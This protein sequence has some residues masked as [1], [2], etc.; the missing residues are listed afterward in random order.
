[1]S[2]IMNGLICNFILTKE[3][4]MILEFTTFTKNLLHQPELQQHI[5]HRQ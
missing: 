2:L 1:M 3:Q 5:V 4:D